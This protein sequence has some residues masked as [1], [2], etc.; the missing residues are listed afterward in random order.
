[1][2]WRIIRINGDG[3]IRMIYD[4]TS[5]HANGESSTDRQ[6][7]TSKFNSIY[8]DNTYVGYM[9]GTIGASTYAATH[10][11]KTDSQVKA[12]I[13]DWY[14]ANLKE[15]TKKRPIKSDFLF[16]GLDNKNR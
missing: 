6:V 8:N 4:G 3:T 15:Y 1:M 14:E 2:W 10:A 13:D 5:A 16:I 9:Y 7:G 11:N 12:F